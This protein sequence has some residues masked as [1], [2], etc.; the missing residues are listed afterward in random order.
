VFAA[1]IHD[2]DHTGLPNTQLVKEKTIIASAYKGKSIA[3]QNSV[4]VAWALLMDDN[5]S[6]IRRIIYSNG[7]ELKRFRQLVV[8]SVMATDILDK[9]LKV[10]RNSRWDRAFQESAAVPENM[11]DTVNRK[12]TIVIEHLIQASD[13]SHTMQHWHIYRKWNERLFH[14]MY[15][16]YQTGHADND[17]SESW[18]KG[19]MGFFDFYIIPL[20][21]K[22]KD[23]GVFGVSS[24]EYLNYAQKN[25]QEWESRGQDVVASM[26]EKFSVMYADHDGARLDD[27][28][29]EEK[30]I[31]RSQLARLDTVSDD[32]IGDADAI[33][34][35]DGIDD[36]EDAVE[37]VPKQ[38]E[39]KDTVAPSN[40][41]PN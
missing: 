13:V 2:V 23:C 29:D 17:P 37:T 11:R 14:E 34:D 24:D 36:D 16:A 6:A 35:A 19:E 7:D 18:Y 4:D 20:A 22:L 38:V 41:R 31:L 40:S 28:Q 27:I 39:T 15:L 30:S 8:N 33:D 10:L 32:G 12:A 21:K 5:F 9:D 25:R 1:L 26:I 3:E